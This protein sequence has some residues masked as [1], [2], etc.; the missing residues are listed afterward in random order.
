MCCNV[1]APFNPAYRSRYRSPTPCCRNSSRH[2]PCGRPES[3]PRLSLVEAGVGDRGHRIRRRG[4]DRHG[5]ADAVRD[6]DPLLPSGVTATPSGPLK[7]RSLMTA[8]TVFIAVAIT[9]TVLP[10]KFAI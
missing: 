4:D 3:P 9:D 6:I 10:L 5:V 8:V 7:L 2:R 1:A